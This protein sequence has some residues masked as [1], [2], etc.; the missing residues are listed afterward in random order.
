MSKQQFENAVKKIVAHAGIAASTVTGLLSCLPGVS[1][2]RHGIQ[3]LTTAAHF[4]ADLYLLIEIGQIY[5]LDQ[6]ETEHNLINT[7]LVTLSSGSA[8]VSDVAIH[9]ALDEF[10]LPAAVKTIIHAGGRTGATVAAG[11]LYA[12]LCEAQYG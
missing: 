3:E 9:V 10:D 11:F 1:K 6:E 2:F 5:G 8:L 12:V 7:G 4:A